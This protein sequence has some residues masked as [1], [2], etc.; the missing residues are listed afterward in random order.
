MKKKIISFI[1][2]M[3][4]SGILIVL[5]RLFTDTLYKL[6]WVENMYFVLI[7]FIVFVIF[8]FADRQ[9]RS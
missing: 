1:L 3:V 6:D 9:E 5:Y 2:S 4:V 7:S 8:L